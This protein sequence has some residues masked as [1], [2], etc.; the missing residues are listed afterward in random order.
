MDVKTQKILAD[1]IADAQ[2]NAVKPY[3]T[4]AKVKGVS[5][6]VVYVEIPGSDR[7]TPVKNS[8]VAVKKGDTVDLVVSHEDTHITGNRS[9]VATSQS[10]TSKLEKVVEANKLQ[11]ENKLDVVG[12]D[13]RLI[14]NTMDIMDS[15][16]EMLASELNIQ[17]SDIEAINSSVKIINS[18]F[19]IKDGKMT[20]IS[21]ILTNILNSGYVKTDLMNADVAWIEDGK[22]KQ[23]AIG[24][25][26][27]ADASI[28]TLKVR[29]L[30]AD[31][32]TAG[33]LKTE[34]LIL[35]TDEI[36]PGTGE[37]KVAL[38][39]A[40]NAKAKSGE[41]DILDGAIIKD[42]TI[43]AAKITVVDLKA[44]GATIGNFNIGTS[45]IY[46]GKESLKD[47]TNGVYIGTDGIAIGQ[48]G[49]L[50]MDDDSPFRVESDGDFHLGGEESNYVNFD[51]FT[52][53]LDIDAKSVKIGS[54]TVATTANV[55]DAID[56]MLIGGRNMCGGTN[57]GTKNWGWSM[58]A[59]TFTKEEVVENGVKTCKLTRNN[60]TQS[61]WSV[62]HFDDIGRDEWLPDTEYTLSV[63]VKTSVATIFALEFM[64]INGTNSLISKKSAKNNATKPNE[65]VTLQWIYTSS[66]SLPTEDG[67]VVYLSN[68]NSDPGISYQFRNLKLEKGN[69]ATD[70]SPAPED[71][72]ADIDE[73]LT[74]YATIEVTD[75][76]ISTAVGTVK[77]YVDDG[78]T[79]ILKE[80][81]SYTDQTTEKI[82]STVEGMDGRLSTVEQKAD[83]FTWGV[84]VGGRNLCQKTNYGTTNWMWSLG[85][86]TADISE[87]DEYGVRTCLMTRGNDTLQGQS[88]IFFDNIGRDKWVPNEEYIV[89]VDV[90]SS[91][92]T[93]FNIDF[94]AKEMWA[95]SSNLINRSETVVGNNTTKVNEWTT[96]IWKIKTLETLRDADA[97]PSNVLCLWGMNS[98]AGVSYQF[99]NLKLEKGNK[100]TDWTA[101]PED[102]EAD[103]KEASR[104]ASKYLRFGSD[105][106]TI[107]QNTEV[108]ELG[109][110]VNITDSTVNVRNGDK[111]IA[112]YGETIELI[113]NDQSIF[114]IS[115]SDFYEKIGGEYVL[116]ETDA[117]N[118]IITWKS[119][120][121]ESLENIYSIEIDNVGNLNSTMVHAWYIHAIDKYILFLPPRVNNHPILHDVQQ[122]IYWPDTQ[123]LDVY[124]SETSFYSIF[125][126][127]IDN[128]IRS[129]VDI[130]GSLYIN[131]KTISNGGDLLLTDALTPVIIGD[132]ND[133]RMEIDSI[134]IGTKKKDVGATLFINP[135]GGDVVLGRR[136]GQLGTSYEET[137]RKLYMNGQTYFNDHLYFN[138]NMTI[139]GM[140]WNGEKYTTRANF[141]PLNSNGNCVL[142]YG[143]YN[144]EKG[145]TNI[146]GYGI[147][148]QTNNYLHSNRSL[149]TLWSGGAGGLYMGA[150]HKVTLSETISNQLNG[151]VLEWSA[152]VANAAQNYWF[153]Q[154]FIPKEFVKKFSGGGIDM[155]LSGRYLGLKYVYITNNVITGS[156]DNNAD[157]VTASGVTFNPNYFVLRNVYGI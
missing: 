153:N 63:D 46:N 52:G 140:E 79:E 69:K 117:D 68:M 55:T 62:I 61:G 75:E 94:F 115:V 22:I 104:T 100:A 41:G 1:V 31:V 59:G 80:S 83:G 49:L 15:D 155:V 64:K 92:A 141:Q 11:M 116:I 105:G 6:G 16:I 18:A 119:L 103:I 50:G 7:L 47:P 151:I 106:L 101:A 37:K 145:A 19:V 112:K 9:D 113:Q 121:D 120:G 26:Q 97:T 96:L 137:G 89:A 118:E 51:S 36:D 10:T 130:T 33:T 21:E 74:N 42:N 148:L 150:S 29:D 127:I 108:E 88:I 17:N 107:S 93:T 77:D 13:I 135:D 58:R 65:W 126:S 136:Y 30:S 123:K 110:N 38:I 72:E 43:E 156:A 35:T 131:N 8:S 67:Q 87:V 81:K 4:T 60:D 53:E 70:W 85:D 71:I 128:A 102:I 40:L 109:R 139:F 20:G 124:T 143:N 57:Q 111:D 66:S 86:G 152:Y 39:T 12:N 28:T 2:R 3:T 125:V 44:F 134:S 114:K 34:R 157:T 138:N 132:I 14:N 78:D 73:K 24:E 142:G 91:V 149:K 82:S 5:N 23:G 76:K 48:G 154:I 27:I 54:K 147:N 32:I 95:D 146:Y 122:L 90:K 25:A 98:D 129:R 99:R 133:E 144:A 56:G 84:K 45:S